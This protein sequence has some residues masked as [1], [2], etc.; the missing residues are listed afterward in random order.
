MSLNQR[1]AELRAENQA[2]IPAEFRTVMAQ[3][4]E[5]L[6]TSG[7]L[8]QV[9]REGDRIPEITLPNA[10][11]KSIRVQDLLAHGPVVISFYRGE[12]C[13]YCNLELRALQQA[14][15]DIQAQGATLVAISPETPDHSLSASEKHELTFEV[16]SDV[17]NQ[18]AREFGLVFKISPELLPIYEK[19]GIDIAAHNGDESYELP[20]PATY[21][22]DRNGTIVHAF[23]D[24]DY[25]QRLEPAEIIEALTQIRAVV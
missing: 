19:F 23:V 18:V 16:L 9:R 4:T 21:V 15:P 5:D 3:A 14:L 17:G 20:I 13:P 12:W 7:I 2:K 1:I 11:G 8:D 24:A 10:V 6:A 25:T 22:V